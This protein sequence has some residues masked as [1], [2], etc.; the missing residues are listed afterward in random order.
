M[1]MR[2]L[3]PTSLASR[4]VTL[5]AMLI[6]AGLAVTPASSAPVISPAAVFVPSMALAQPVP[7]AAGA[8]LR[9]ARQALDQAVVVRCCTSSKM[10]SDQ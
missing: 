9:D 10:L 3:N 1:D 7:D 2:E 8:A 6:A 4:G 5:A